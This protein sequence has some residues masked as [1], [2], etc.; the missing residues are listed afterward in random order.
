MAVN[1]PMVLISREM[2]KK[3]LK[4]VPDGEARA[5]KLGFVAGFMGGG[6]LPAIVVQ[7]IAK[8][9]AADLAVLPPPAAVVTPVVVSPPGQLP[10]PPGFVKLPDTVTQPLD[11]A[12]KALTDFTVSEF[13]TPDA[14]A[15]PANL[16]V[17]EQTPRG[18]GLAATASGVLIAAAARTVDVPASPI[19]ATVREV[20]AAVA[21]LSADL[22]VQAR[23]L[24]AKGAPED[25]KDDDHVLET[26]P[27]GVSVPF[28][29][30]VYVL[31]KAAAAQG[32]VIK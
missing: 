18:P 32:G 24:D 4:D 10:P 6:F 19:A 5:N 31:A 23:R 9:D 22:K 21:K 8:R 17:I 13:P 15:N 7:Q 11:T 29:D 25:A 30:T 12:R 16:V 1:I 20:R 2:A 14:K 3:E 27:A 28:N 26:F